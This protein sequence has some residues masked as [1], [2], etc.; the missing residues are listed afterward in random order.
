MSAESRVHSE[1]G[2]F[3]EGIWARV[4]KA[5][6]LNPAIAIITRGTDEIGAIEW[7]IDC[8]NM[9]IWRLAG[10]GWQSIGDPLWE[11]YTA[12]WS[13]GHITELSRPKPCVDRPG[14]RLA[15]PAWYCE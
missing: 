14:W 1:V 2:A 7:E 13:D 15:C 3:I 4:Y 10:K 9:K 5:L 11:E 8:G 6:G 12:I